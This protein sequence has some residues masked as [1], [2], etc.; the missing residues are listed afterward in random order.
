MNSEL[1]C[2]FRSC[3]AAQ[4]LVAADALKRTA[5]ARRTRTAGLAA[6]QHHA[7]RKREQRG[8]RRRPR[9]ENLRASTTSFLWVLQHEFAAWGGRRCDLLVRVH[10]LLGLLQSQTLWHLSQLR[11]RAGASASAP[12]SKTGQVPRFCRAGPQTPGL[13]R[14]RGI[15]FL[16]VARNGSNFSLQPTTRSLRS[17]AAAEL[18]R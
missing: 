6:D 18:R 15:V 10:V 14:R 17:W 16:E 11:R 1:S 7:K 8:N 13:W 12:N 9:Q 4:P 3:N 2:E 5:A